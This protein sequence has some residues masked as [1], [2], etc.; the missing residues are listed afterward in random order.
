VGDVHLTQ[1]E[2]I[3]RNLGCIDR[4]VFRSPL[5]R[6]GREHQRRFVNLSGEGS[7]TNR[8]PFRHRSSA[9]GR[10]DGSELRDDRARAPVADAGAPLEPVNDKEAV[11]DFA[12]RA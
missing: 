7:W 8:R 2:P 9:V 4:D 5:T 10:G 3:A 1:F 11:W 12:R 6:I